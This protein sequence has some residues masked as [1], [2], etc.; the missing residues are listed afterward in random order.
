M[1]QNI[2]ETGIEWSN[3]QVWG[4]VAP[5]IQQ[6]AKDYNDR[7]DD[8][9]KLKISLQQQAEKAKQAQALEALKLQQKQQIATDAEMQ[10]YGR[11]LG[12]L[13]PEDATILSQGY[14]ERDLRAGEYKLKTGKNPYDASNFDPE[15]IAIRDIHNGL[16]LEKSRAEARRKGYTSLDLTNIDPEQQDQV[17]QSLAEYKAKFNPETKWSDLRNIDHQWG[18]KTVAPLQ[19]REVLDFTSRAKLAGENRVKTG[20]EQNPTGTFL[21]AVTDE[22]L[23]EDKARSAMIASLTPKD[24]ELAQ[25]DVR[26]AKMVKD[27]KG[28][29][30]PQP[31][32]DEKTGKQKIKKYKDGSIIPLYEVDETKLHEHAVSQIPRPTVYET[33]ENRSKTPTTI[34]NNNSGSESGGSWSKGKGASSIP[35]I[36]KPV[37]SSTPRLLGGTMGKNMSIA[38]INSSVGAKTTL[39]N[40][41]IVINPNTSGA[42]SN[43]KLVPQKF[44][45]AGILSAVSP[46]ELKQLVNQEALF[47]STPQI[48]YF[49]VN[50]SG[51]IVQNAQGDDAFS[52][53]KDDRVV[54]GA[55]PFIKARV[56]V[57]R[58]VTEKG[59]QVEKEFD[60]DIYIPASSLD[61]EIPQWLDRPWLEQK[62]YGIDKTLPKTAAKKF[63]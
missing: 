38:Q 62:G 36:I 39:G 14:D 48:E 15:A 29:I 50:I 12:D 56:K 54:V 11:K 19:D 3:P 30:V 7:A 25:E 57:K 41:T 24:Y 46:E 2:G 42:K 58:M 52:I 37:T 28:N 10:K 16:E 43:I 18:Y 32:W 51:N 33:K 4:S 63:E 31:I 55:A 47:D 59:K 22:R 40:N 6:Y 20:K 21:T 5:L 17:A 34:V 60:E 26:F 8:H 27:E 1:I 44:N 23:D 45:Q 13:F 61:A 53:M 35:L 9:T 49:P